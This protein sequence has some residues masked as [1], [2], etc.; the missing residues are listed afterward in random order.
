MI[1]IGQLACLWG[2]PTEQVKRFPAVARLDE[3]GGQGGD[4][5][6]QSDAD[7]EPQQQGQERDGGDARADD[8]QGLRQEHQGAKPGFPL[9]AL[10]HVVEGGVFVEGQVEGERLFDDR[11]VDAVAQQV[12]EQ[13][14]G[15]LSAATQQRA[16]QSQAKGQGDGR[17]DAVQAQSRIADGLHHA[18][19][20]ELA[21]VGVGGGQEALG[22]GGE[23]HDQGQG[24]AAS[25][26]QVQ[27]LDRAGEN[28]FWRTEDGLALS[29]IRVKYHPDSPLS[30]TF[31]CGEQC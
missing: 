8:G 5:Q 9:S 26:H 27:D 24:G 25:P 11:L 16:H 10:E 29:F 7:V 28:S 14:L 1:V 23:G 13:F 18:V 21:G 20:D 6:D 3:Q 30:L 2:P 22:Q 17:Q 15:E 4:H 19:H 12:A 31:V